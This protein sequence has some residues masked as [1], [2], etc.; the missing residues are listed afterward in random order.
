MQETRAWSLGQEGS[1][2][3]RKWQPPPVFLPGDSHGQKSFVGL[4]YMGSQRVRCDWGTNFYTV[5][6]YL[7]IQNIKWPGNRT[8][9]PAVDGRNRKYVISYVHF[10]LCCSHTISHHRWVL[11]TDGLLLKILFQEPQ[12]NFPPNYPKRLDGNKA[13]KQVFVIT[14]LQ[15]FNE[16]L[17]SAVCWENLPHTGMTGWRDQLRFFFSLCHIPTPLKISKGPQK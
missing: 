6:I 8:N 4:Q 10:F 13:S 17:Q 3:R 11:S 1:P 12:R 2:W 15:E 7:S 14:V 16:F 9:S 5:Y